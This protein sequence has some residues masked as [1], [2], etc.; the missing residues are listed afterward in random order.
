MFI[1]FLTVSGYVFWAII[2]AVVLLEIILLTGETEDLPFPAVMAIIT[3]GGVALFTDAFVGFE[4]KWLLAAV[5]VY[6]AVGAIWS[7]K[8]WYSFVVEIRDDARRSYELHANKSAPGNE[9][10]ASYSK[11]MR[12]TAAKHKQRIITWMTLWPFSFTWW[13]LTWPRRFFTWVYDRL[14][15]LYDRIAERVFAA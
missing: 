13:C 2:A 14:S 8:K 6:A 9:T 5:I 12:P 3:L 11:G 10:W 15:T 4:L 7:I 1:E